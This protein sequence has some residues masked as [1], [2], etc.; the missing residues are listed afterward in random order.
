MVLLDTC[1]LL[2]LSQASSP[3]PTPVVKAIRG[4]PPTGRFVSAITAFE[5]GYKFALGKL[6]LSKPPSV[7]FPEVCAKRGLTVFPITDSV[8]LRASALPRH[9]R[10]PADRFI[11]STAQELSLTILTPDPFFDLYDVDTLWS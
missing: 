3:L 9:H 11:I 4:T 7:W 5:I 1:T 6:V 2:W 10:D 8:A